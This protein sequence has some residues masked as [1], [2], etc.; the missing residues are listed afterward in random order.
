MSYDGSS[1]AEGVKLYLDEKLAEVDVIRDKLTKD[2]T[3][4]GEPNL[5]VGYRFRDNGFKNGLV[6][7]LKVWNRAV[8]LAEIVEKPTDGMLYPYFVSTV[9]EP[10]MKA[11]A[12]LRT[13][14]KAYTA[15]INPIPEIMV[16]DE[17][18]V[19][20]PAYILKRGAYDSRG[21]AVTA[22]TPK[23]LPPFPKEAPRNRLGLAQWLTDP[24]NPL[25]ATSR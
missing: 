9:Y 21:D 7:E 6:D 3:Y 15:F 23:A 16:M 8:T 19:P 12:E 24:G 4:G 20:K 17:M 10:S 18:P 14:R 5:A 11:A 13:A 25:F 22:D 1:R 2:I